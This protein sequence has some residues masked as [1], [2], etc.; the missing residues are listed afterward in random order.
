M[1]VFQGI[2]A[3]ILGA[4]AISVPAGTTPTTTSPT[5]VKC[6]MNMMAQV[7]ASSESSG[8]GPH[9]EMPVF[10]DRFTRGGVIGSTHSDR[11][12]DLNCADTVPAKAR[13]AGVGKVTAGCQG[14]S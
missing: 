8:T 3:Q 14:W 4:S 9:F 6:S 7:D 10:V 11:G 1:T 5:R 2:F 13:R 12:V